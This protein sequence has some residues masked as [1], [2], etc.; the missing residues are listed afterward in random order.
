M[1]RFL[2]NLKLKTK[3][4]GGFLLVAIV[5]TIV[6]GIGYWGIVGL[7]GRIHEIADVRLPSVAS[8]LE[9]KIG[10]ERVKAVQRTLLD[11]DLDPVTRER[12]PQVLAAAR[13]QYEEAWKIYEPLPQTVEEAEVWK[14]FVPAWQLWRNDNNEFFRLEQEV[15]SLNVGNPLRLLATLAGGRADHAALVLQTLQMVGSKQVFD[16]GEDHTQCAFGKWLASQKLDNPQVR[17]ILQEVEKP[18]HRLHEVVAKI[19]QLVKAGD[20]QAAEKLCKT[21]L[22]PLSADIVTQLGRLTDIARRAQDLAGKAQRQATEVCRASMDKANALLDQLVKLNNGYAAN[23]A[24][25]SRGDAS[26]AK[27][28]AVFT[29]GVGLVAAVILGVVLALMISRPVQKVAVVLKAMADGDYSQRVDHQAKDEIGQMAE[30]L[31]VAIA[32]TGKAMQEVRDASEAAR[33]AGEREKEARERE[34]EQAEALRRKVNHLLEVVSAAAQG[35]LTRTVEVEGTEAV[36]ELAAGIGKMLHD[37]SAVIAQVAEGAQQFAEGSRVIAESSQTLAS[38]AQQQSSSVEEMTASI[39]ELTRA[40]ESVKEGANEANRVAGDASRLADEGGQAVT[41]SV[42]SM[43][44]IR[45]SS[46]Q[47]SEIIQVISEIAS[48]TNLLALNAAIEA[49]RAGEHGM[50]FA[51]VADEV[52]K[53][54]ERSNQAAREISSL[55]KESSKRVEEGAALSDQAG[56]SL[57]QIIGAVEGTAAKIAEIAAATVQQAANA[58]EVSKSIQTVAQ[59]TEQTAAGSEEMASSSEELGAQANMLRDVVSRFKITTNSKSRV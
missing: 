2:S 12:Q 1:S 17:A 37:L 51:V 20:T 57:K 48:Q 32:A 47:I 38:G 9:I 59:V 42:E 49:A 45:T 5:T 35:D 7:G 11:P 58:Q 29:T 33:V 3:L 6:G 15:S 19:K 40:I 53:L 43:A 56:N 13:K 41:R 31:N 25:L 44:L 14:Q 24:Q 23:E 28:L 30:A 54:A 22:S 16:G 10:A 26:R 52:R 18:H 27:S 4:L 46:Q 36:D 39:E 55:I 34:K 21:E 8:L 50:G